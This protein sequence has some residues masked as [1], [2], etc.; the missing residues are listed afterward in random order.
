MTRPYTILSCAMSVDGRIDDAGP[1]R[2]RLS[3]EADF[4]E[5]DELRAGCDA[6]LVGAETIRRD[7]PRLLVRSAARREARLAAGRSASLTRV[8]LSGTGDLAPTAR[9][10]GGDAAT[11][12]YVGACGYPAAARRFADACRVEVVPAG[13][14]PD[15]RWITADLAGR[16]VR[17]LLVEG[18]GAVHT[19]FLTAGLA[20]E[21][22]LAVAPFFVGG[23]AAPT[24]V[25][26]G[27][28]PHGPDHPMRLAEARTIGGI[29]V[30]RYLLDGAAS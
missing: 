8:V 21:I 4:D 28:F 16:G 12:F 17:R 10:F 5:V 27:R 15:I 30:L 9:V 25:R 23:A 3:N 7:D 6:I 24:F 14:E 2:L 19:A 1:D 29:V 13:V 26:P 18:G 11:L 22:R 20:D